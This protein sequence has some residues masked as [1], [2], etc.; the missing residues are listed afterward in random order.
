MYNYQMSPPILNAMRYRSL[1]LDTI[2]KVPNA[3]C[4]L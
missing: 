2:I 4:Y 3:C 1:L